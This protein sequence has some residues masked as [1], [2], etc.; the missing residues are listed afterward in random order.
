MKGT[1]VWS[2]CVLVP[3]LLFGSLSCHADEIIFSKDIQHKQ[4]I[5]ARHDFLWPPANNEEK[6]ADA[7]WLK[8]HPGGQLTSAKYGYTYSFYLIADSQTRPPE[9][10]VI[11]KKQL[12][13]KQT[14]I[15]KKRDFL[16]PPQTEAEKAA[17]RKYEKEHPGF[18]VGN[19]AKYGYEYS[20]VRTS[21][22]GSQKSLLW[23]FKTGTFQPYNPENPVVRI[24]DVALQNK[25]L[26]TLYQDYG[27][28][29]CNII[30]VNDKTPAQS[31]ALS[32]QEALLIPDD[33]FRKKFPYG[34][35]GLYSAV[36][37]GSLSKGNL[38]VVVDKGYPSA[39]AF[40]WKDKKWV[41]EDLSNQP[42]MEKP[43]VIG[44]KKWL[45][46]LTQREGVTHSV[47][48]YGETQFH[49]MTGFELRLARKPFVPSSG[50]SSSTRSTSLDK[51]NKPQTS[52]ATLNAKAALQAS[53]AQLLWA[54][55]FNGSLFGQPNK[56]WLADVYVDEAEN[57][58]YLALNYDNN[59]WVQVLDADTVIK[60]IAVNFRG[61]PVVSAARQFLDDYDLPPWV[62]RTEDDMPETLN[63]NLPYLRSI[64]IE[65][66]KGELFL[67]L[68]G[69]QSPIELE[70]A[71]RTESLRWIFDTKEK[72]WRI[73][74]IKPTPPASNKY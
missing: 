20:F 65:K 31:K 52:N 1:T 30:Q 43:V 71:F 66:V 15:V 39:R 24:F 27:S 50:A 49:D 4:I 68:S 11:F 57:K 10:K 36:I 45:L 5:V 37:T 26:I 21:K 42:I 73:T 9:M 16:W 51:G 22:E 53:Q 12:S 8:E 38:T 55:F 41:Y 47:K 3:L 56:R 60:N 62:L 70:Q 74:A 33:T 14:V 61:M 72:V 19:P 69:S 28:L 2:D 44:G 40:H 29:Q 18:S 35:D 32:Y 59:T 34:T 6:A 25:K 63:K 46:E 48:D 54:V 58:I 67:T 7:K 64:H 23:S 13:Q 17:N